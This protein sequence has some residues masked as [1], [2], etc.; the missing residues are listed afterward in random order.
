MSK[1]PTVP[2]CTCGMSGELGHGL[3]ADTCKRW[4]AIVQKYRPR[5][6]R[7]EAGKVIREQ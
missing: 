3:H 5:G 6:L 7:V 1:E 4:I 2:D